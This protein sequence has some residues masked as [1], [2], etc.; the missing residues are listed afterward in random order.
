MI[1]KLE[2]W[3]KY[4]NWE[5]KPNFDTCHRHKDFKDFKN[6]YYTTNELEIMIENIFHQLDSETSYNVRFMGKK[7]SGKTTFLH[8]V[9]RN[10]I[11]NQFSEKYF[12]T[13]VRTGKVALKDYNLS[14]KKLFVEHVFKKFYFHCQLE[15]EYNRIIENSKNDIEIAL[16]DLQTLYFNDDGIR[17]KKRLITVLD[18][19][20]TLKEDQDIINIVST[21]KRICGSG[22]KI[23]KWVSI[24]ELTF[25]NYSKK[26]QDEFTFFQHPL[27]LNVTC[28]Y[29]IVKKRIYAKNNENAM[30]PFSK[31]ICDDL[32]NLHDN[33]LRDSL[34]LL[35]NLLSNTRIPDKKQHQE[36]IQNWY[37][38]KF[39]L[40]Y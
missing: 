17:F 32:S 10:L 18:D 8:Y 37:I 21:F 11:E 25:N 20:D 6:E 14:L 29:E 36:F 27:K 4:L 40:Y 3:Y 5:N 24:R 2:D 22:D 23:N 15:D 9:K 31:L 1:T 33:S 26:V 13:I 30:N 35:D 16:Q 12:F 7:G 38:K 19:L 34:G 39:H 28:L